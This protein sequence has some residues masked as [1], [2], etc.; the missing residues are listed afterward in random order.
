MG[1][2]G[3]FAL[4]AL[5]ALRALGAFGAFGFLSSLA[6]KAVSS[7]LEAGAFGAFGF[8]SFLAWTA[9]SSELEEEGTST[10][11]ATG[12]FDSRA[13]L[14]DEPAGA[15][16]ALRFCGAF[17]AS[18]RVAAG[19]DLVAASSVCVNGW[20]TRLARAASGVGEMA[21]DGVA[22][23]APGVT[24]GPDGATPA[25]AVTLIAGSIPA[26]DCA[27]AALDAAGPSI[28]GGLG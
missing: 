27:E 26:G 2:L 9:V 28:A 22:V 3:A 7:E 6:G 17:P 23:S 19:S 13:G 1:A 10:Y 25:V 21:K 11:A 20:A 24:T 15:G 4:G 16:G 12:A 5:G 18:E 14:L 8:L